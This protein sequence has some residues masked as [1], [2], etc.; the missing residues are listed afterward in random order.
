MNLSDITALVLSFDE[1]ANLARTLERLRWAGRVVL[2]DS[3]SSDSTL[4]I[5]ARFPN[6]SVAVRSFDGHA[7]QWN[8]GLTLCATPW[9]LTL[10]ADYVLGDGFEAELERLNPSERSAF[11]ARFRFLV[12]G[13][14]LRA[15]LYPPRAVLF[16]RDRCH[17]EQDGHTQ[18][19]RVDGAT[20]ELE[21]RIDH[22][23]RKSLARWL[24]QQDRYAALEVD[25]LR[26]I[27]ADQ[28]RLQDRL[29]KTGWAAVPLAPIYALF[30]RGAV[31]DGWPGLHY[32]MQRTVA[33]A[34]L[35]MHI[36]EERARF[37]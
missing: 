20:G 1:E 34:I 2:L 8:H 25:K 21:T 10:D 32:A 29:R 15:S 24:R 6:V 11:Y 31:L 16:R 30:A 13:R 26:A 35:A 23:D 28:L 17:Y 36:A 5:A 9:A 27:P 4:A 14:P 7:S 3:G 12:L 22:D 33:E 19:L 37:R 18:L